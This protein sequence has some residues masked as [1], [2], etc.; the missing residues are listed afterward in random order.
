MHFLLRST[1]RKYNEKTTVHNF[2]NMTLLLFIASYVTIGRWV[3]IFSSGAS[4]VFAYIEQ[5]VSI[6][7][8]LYSLCIAL[9]PYGYKHLQLH[10][11]RTENSYQL[12]PAAEKLLLKYRSYRGNIYY[13]LLELTEELHGPMKNAFN[14]FV[15]ALQAK[16][17][18]N[19]EEAAELFYYQIQTSW[20]RQLGIQ[21]MKAAKD[22]KQI[23]KALARIHEDMKDVS[24]L[25]EK[26]KSENLETIQMGYLPIVMLPVSIWGN[27][28][29]SGGA[30]LHY[31]LNDPIG[32]KYLLFTVI[33][34]VVS[35]FTAV[36]LRKPKNEV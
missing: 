23:G 11:I 26:A 10:R 21:I 30:V 33:V 8:L 1:N 24:Q 12:T 22:G 27:E 3:G 28:Y 25:I 13:A 36:I 17:Q 32:V 31:Y 29:L 4:S 2:L 16:G 34:C 20:A 35:F 15:S 9:V 14:V 5:S 19:I 18:K 6:P 7:V